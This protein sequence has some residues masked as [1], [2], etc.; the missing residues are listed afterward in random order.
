[1]GFFSS[2]FPC[3]MEIAVFLI[4]EI[5]FFKIENAEVLVIITV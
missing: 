2:L 3:G 4:E 1:M 5:S